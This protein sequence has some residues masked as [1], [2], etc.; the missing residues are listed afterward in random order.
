MFDPA[1]VS[2]SMTFRATNFVPYLALYTQPWAPPPSLSGEPGPKTNEKVCPGIVSN[3]TAARLLAAPAAEAGEL[4]LCCCWNMAAA[5]FMTRASKTEA[6]IMFC[7]TAASSSWMVPTLSSSFSKSPCMFSNSLAY[8]AS[9]CASTR[10]A[11]IL[12]LSLSSSACT[13]GLFTN[14]VR[15]PSNFLICAHS[16][17]KSAWASAGFEWSSWTKLLRRARNVCTAAAAALFLGS[18]PGSSRSSSEKSVMSHLLIWP[19]LTFSSPC[20][21]TR[22][23]M[24][25]CFLTWLSSSAPLLPCDHGFRI[26]CSHAWHSTGPRI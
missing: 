25:G 17:S 13:S 10:S 5:T 3:C 24:S 8:L 9:F 1:G 26:F 22:F 19:N 16:L 14:A 23:I 11:R 6:V 20:L 15:S 7:L 21:P 18:S 2:G 12:L 4:A